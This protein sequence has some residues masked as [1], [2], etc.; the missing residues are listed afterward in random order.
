[1]TRA[2]SA[3]DT[4]ELTPAPFSPAPVQEVLRLLAKAARAHQLYLPNN[5]IHRSAIEAFRAGFTPIW[6][7]TDELVLAIAETEVQWYGVSVLS[8]DKTA[9]NIAWL[10]FKDGVR[11][12]RLM[13]GIEES[14]I[15]KLI[16][17]VNRGRRASPDDD[18]LVAMLW[19]ADFAYLSYRH[20]DL[21]SEGD[22]NFPA[23][24]AGSDVPP[25]EIR[26]LTEEAVQEARA[27]G[28]VRLEDFDSTLYFL[29][30]RE[31]EYVQRELKLE[32][33][34]DLRGNVIAA[35]LDTF[36]SQTDNSV[37]DE[38]I[39]DVYELMVHLLAAGHFIGVANV[40]REV[41]VAIE[42]AGDVT[43]EQHA[44]LARL[45]EQLS[46]PESLSQ[47]IQALDDT[48]I[49]PPEGELAEL[50]DQLR[51][52]ALAPVFLWLSRIRNEALRPLLAAAADR[53]AA[54]N[55][56]ELVSLIDAPDQEISNE[57]IRRAGAL[58]AQAAVAVLG[59]VMS[60]PDADRRLRAAQALSEIASPGAFQV[61]ERA[62][63]DSAREVRI[64]AVRTLASHSFRPMLPRLEAAVKAPTLREADLTEKMAFFEAYGSLCGDAGVAYLDSILNGRSLFGRRDD[65]EIRACAA[66]SLGRIGTELAF[67]ALRRSSAEKDVVVRNAVSRALRG[68]GGQ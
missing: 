66:I 24:G 8:G 38:I 55:T 65:T 53:L 18:D 40:L 29:D 56:A 35:L 61:L 7:E 67:E 17:L 58:K 11:E 15:V 41:R 2:T 44:R 33:E 5:P 62:I 46:A 63:A 51:P 68:T 21:L 52:S 37:R 47:L 22:A 32:Y 59:K 42:R 25:A 9:D 10:F 20:V 27:H 28:I 57:A 49:L 50:F 30:E 31:T 54:A 23:P 45:A 60:E 26:A 14:E 16:E 64:S 34:G 1:M 36:E 43:P 3:G 6:N 39:D 19:E 48:P 4:I 12:L 13:R